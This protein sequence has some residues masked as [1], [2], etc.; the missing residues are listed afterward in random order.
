[1]MTESDLNDIIRSEAKRLG[2]HWRRFE[3]P[4]ARGYPDGFLGRPSAP[5]GLP[6]FVWVE[7]K[8]LRNS[9]EQPVYRTGQLE[10]AAEASR[11]KEVAMTIAIWGPPAG[12]PFFKVW[13]TADV[14]HSAAFGIIHPASIF[15]TTSIEAALWFCLRQKP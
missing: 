5:Q 3:V 15:Q 14:A 6:S 10:W 2:L 8:A 11:F 13:N 4:M 1:M 7:L 12:D 9:G